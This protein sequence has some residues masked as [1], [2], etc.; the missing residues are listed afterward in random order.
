[1]YAKPPA[2]GLWGI[3][4]LYA[5]R[6]R[7]RRP[8]GAPAPRPPTC[9]RQRRRTSLRRRASP[10]SPRLSRRVTPASSRRASTQRTAL[11]VVMAACL[12]DTPEQLGQHSSRR[13][14][15]GTSRKLHRLASSS[16]TPTDPPQWRM[17]CNRSRPMRLHRADGSGR[18]HSRR[19]LQPRLGSPHGLGQRGTPKLQR[20]LGAAPRRQPRRRG[21]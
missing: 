2:G 16:P 9:A 6:L 12:A 19:S 5:G 17:R 4:A 3:H 8:G 18:T 1:M 10:P 14:C 21:A 11:T 20:L 7:R 13:S 15:R